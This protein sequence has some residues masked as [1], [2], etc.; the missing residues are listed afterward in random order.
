[1][2]RDRIAIE[3]GRLV[4]SA[5]GNADLT[6]DQVVKRVKKIGKKLSK[7]QLQR[8]EAGECYPGPRSRAALS[9]KDV[10]DM[11]G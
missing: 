5:R 6:Q 10:L 3:Y 1:M 9:H 8:I 4:A 2:K 7:R 11:K